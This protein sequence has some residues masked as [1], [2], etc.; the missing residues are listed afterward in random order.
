MMIFL[1][2][3]EHQEILD[4]GLLNGDEFSFRG[5]NYRLLVNDSMLK[6]IPIVDDL[7]VLA[8]DVKKAISLAMLHS[9]RRDLPIY[10]KPVLSLSLGRVTE[11]LACISAATGTAGAIPS[12]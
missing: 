12:D 6:W 1:R 5:T 2:E 11:G 10:K 9:L 7:K 3:R 8:K 4:E